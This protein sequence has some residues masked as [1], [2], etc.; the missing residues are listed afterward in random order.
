MKTSS[1]I[2]LM[3]L[4]IALTPV[5]NAQ[6]GAIINIIGGGYTAGKA[7]QEKERMDKERDAWQ[8]QKEAERI[9]REERRKTERAQQ[10]A[11]LEAK[12]AEDERKAEERAEAVR[13]KRIAPATI[14]DLEA[15]YDPADGWDI[16]ASPK[17]KPDR[18]QYVISGTISRNVS[19]GILLCETVPE[20]E[21]FIGHYFTVRFSKKTKKSRDILDRMR[22]GGRLFVVG[23]YVG[24]LNYQTVAGAWKV[25]PIFDADHLIVPDD[26]D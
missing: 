22:I 10:Q 5:A 17:V 12:M 15:L 9:E 13:A 23:K 25:M 21:E 11:A 6:I 18:A 7:Q 14:E 24:N 19:D 26:A 4:C 8:Q 2:V 20:K 1:K 3:A 16:A